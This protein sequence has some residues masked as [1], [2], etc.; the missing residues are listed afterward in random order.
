MKRFEYLEQ[1]ATA[2]LAVKSYGA[3]LGEAFVNMALAMF[4]AMT[5][6]EKIEPRVERAFEVSGGDLGELLYN[7]LEEFLFL[8]D[9]ENLVFSRISVELDED[10]IELKASCWGEPFD[11]GRHEAGA[12]IKAITYHLMEVK[13]EGD[14]WSLR[15]VFDI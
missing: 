11:L 5:P 4:N 1:E 12:E 9:V 10:K 7:F 2:D 14:L 15:V 8:K 6:L 13:R 3:T